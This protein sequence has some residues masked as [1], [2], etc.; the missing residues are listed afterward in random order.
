[1]DAVA[2]EIFV[3]NYNGAALLAECLPSIVRAARGSSFACTVTVVDNA[4]TDDSSTLLARDFPDVGVLRFTNDGLCSFQRAAAQ[5]KA[6]VVLLL[7]NDIRLEP[8][9]VDPLVRPIVASRMIPSRTAALYSPT[10]A[11]DADEVPSSDEPI[12]WTAPRCHLFDGT[13]YEGFKTAVRMRRGLVQATALYPGCERSLAEPGD[14]ASAGAALAIDRAA[15]VALGGFDSVYLPG[16][17]E[18]LDFAYRAF[19]AGYRGWYVPDSVAYH[20]GAATFGPAFGAAGCDRLAL[21]NTL[22]FQWLRLRRP[23]HL[24]AQACWL[25]LRAVR[26]VV[27]AP[28]A[29]SGERFVFLRAAT[30]AL[31]LVRRARKAGN[32]AP[33]HLDRERAYFRR[34]A[35]DR[36]RRTAA[37]RAAA[38]TWRRAEA[39]R[40][41][42]YPLSQRWLRPAALRIAEVLEPTAVRPWHVTLAGLVLAIVAGGALFAGVSGPAV[43]ALVLTAWLC[44]RIDGPL[45]RLRKTADR[46]GAWLDANIDEAV[47]LGLH[48]VAASIAATHI[49]PRWAWG[50][51]IGFIFGKYLV[52]YGLAVEAES[53]GEDPPPRSA[54]GTAPA[55]WLR[56]LY[57]LPANADVRIH[58]FTA[59][60]AT[61]CLWQELLFTACYYNLRW[62]VRY[63]LVGRRLWRTS[64]VGAAA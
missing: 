19:L 56:R 2:V 40:G 12:L 13:T 41:R 51:L 18:D 23:S 3:L 30:A 59:A 43:A 21:R 54:Y 36:L 25:P 61:G 6:D 46:F 5:S 31:T 35:P 42:N 50:S 48:T 4:S 64:V 38:A 52:M 33:N 60:V 1:M 16:R 29:A 63:V 39:L 53:A 55:A 14:T 8:G 37:E 10:C 44:D 28:W 26:D 17:I 58:L 47:D 22:V 11:P 20:R 57:H 34:Y 9:A 15:F 45:A 27:L 7:N 24:A 49:D 62:P 32:V